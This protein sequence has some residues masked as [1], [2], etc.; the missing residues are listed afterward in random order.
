MSRTK[1]TPVHAN[2]VRTPVYQTATYFFG[3]TQEVV[4]YHE[5]DVVRGRYGRYSNPNW[6]DVETF[7][8]D[9]DATDEALV[10]ASGMNAIA[11]TLLALTSP[12]E[13]LFYTASCYRNTR[14]LFTQILTRFG[15]ATRGFDTVDPRALEER[16]EEAC[17]HTPPRLVFVEM[18]SNPHNY[19]VDLTRIRE[20]LPEQTLLVV[21][22]TFGTPINI[23]PCRF[24]ADLVIHSCTKYLGGHGDVMGGSVAGRRD[25]IDAIRVYRNVLGGVMDPHCA[26][27]LYRSLETLGLR[28]GHFNQ[29][30]LAL[31]R[32]LDAS[33]HVGRVFYTGLDS[34]PHK[35]LADRYLTGHGG[36]V[37][38][39]I[40][41]DAAATT[42][43]VEALEIP[44]M[45]SN[46]GA[47]L[48]LVEQCGI[49][50]YYHCTEEERAALDIS[51]QLVRYSAGY[52][53][54]AS[55]IADIEAAFAKAL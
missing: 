15:I 36:V 47:G 13:T 29:T 18:P 12:G 25:L 51:D 35:A 48:A 38:F 42:R 49:F 7:L 26:S 40:K 23:Q 43:F 33:P 20:I 1:T 55:L 34:H 28:M 16:I 17:R 46:F 39:E 8:A 6:T 31:A 5:K 52:Q 4:E 11:T 45:G 44:F 14:T 37:S 41:G 30:G 19:L 10:F 2:S 27:L 24:G 53:D 32:H 3:S 54:A 9:A 21:D 22:A 50:S